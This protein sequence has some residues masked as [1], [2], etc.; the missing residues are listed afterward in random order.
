MRKDKVYEMKF[1]KN[2]NIQHKFLLAMLCCVTIPILLL[3][4]YII[5]Q[6]ADV[7]QSNYRY[8][9]TQIKENMNRSIEYEFAN[10]D[11]AAYNIYSNF[12]M[13]VDI[14]SRKPNVNYYTVHNALTDIFSSYSSATG[15]N[16]LLNINFYNAENELL[17]YY[18][19]YRPATLKGSIPN[20]FQYYVKT[21]KDTGKIQNLLVFIKD[22]T[23]NMNVVRY[24][25]PIVFRGKYI[26]F[27][28]FTL[29]AKVLSEAIESFNQFHNGK[30]FIV[31]GNNQIMYDSYITQTGVNFKSIDTANKNIVTKHIDNINSDL[32]YLY[33]DSASTKISIYITIIVLFLAILIVIYISYILSR[34]I[35]EPIVMLSKSMGS[36]KLGNYNTKVNVE[37]NDE[38]GELGKI[39][40]EMT[41]TIQRYIE[42]EVK[43]KLDFKDAQIG[44]LQAQISPHFLHNT[45]QA[46]TNMAAE[47]N[48]NDINTICKSLS[49]MYRFNMNINEKYTDLNNEVMN[50]RNYMLI[51]SKRYNNAINFKIRIPSSLLCIQV[52]KLILQPIVENAVMHGLLFS[53]NEDKSLEIT[54]DKNENNEVLY[55]YVNDNGR[56]ISEDE[57]LQINNNL[58]NANYQEKFQ[59]YDSIGVYNVQKRINL[60]CGNQYG[61]H[62]KS[63]LSVGTC[64]TYT[65]PLIRRDG[66]ANIDS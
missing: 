36:I 28:E 9:Q 42:Y 52:P 20:N 21:M 11:N 37:S 15:R 57:V 51:I 43:S 26:G 40:N 64:I 22:K 32:I 50:V 59:S 2:F 54:V 6:T 47:S 19:Y 7:E 5:H 55:I 66:N 60:L 23:F 29:D 45:L 58:V 24:Y 14:E 31:S 53:P 65:L 39:Y 27:L 4:F 34:K 62:F 49:D 38:I 16:N 33:E 61:M 13:L 35:T 44:T 63:Q 1:I 3:S 48:T 8:A 10:L 17:N 56:G 12:N 30:V 25:Y 41:D 18:L 46:I